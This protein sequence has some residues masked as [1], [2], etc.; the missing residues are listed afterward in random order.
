MAL[1]SC[2]FP[3]SVETAQV[4]HQLDDDRRQQAISVVVQMAFNLVK[5]QTT[6][7]QPEEYDDHVFTI[8]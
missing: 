6:S 7:C 8:D 4:W 2:H 1:L 5:T 3:S